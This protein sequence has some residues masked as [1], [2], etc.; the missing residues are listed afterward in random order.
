MAR[1]GSQLKMTHQS[2]LELYTQRL[3]QIKKLK[4]KE[5]VAPVLA[6]QSKKKII[7]AFGGCNDL[8]LNNNRKF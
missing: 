7:M 6:H 2:G 1:V 4:L 8:G 3:N 5:S